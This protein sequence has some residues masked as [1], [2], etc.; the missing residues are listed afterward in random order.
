V[1]GT[2]LPT[3]YG[4]RVYD[5]PV[6]PLGPSSDRPA[7]PVPGSPGVPPPSPFESRFKSRIEPPAA[8]IRA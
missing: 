2:K 5:N 3:I 8:H 4:I 6:I 7:P 1:P